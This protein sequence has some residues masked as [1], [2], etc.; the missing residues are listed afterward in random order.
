MTTALVQNKA[1]IMPQTTTLT[2]PQESEKVEIKNLNDFTEKIET[3]IPTCGTIE[4]TEEQ[5]KALYGPVNERDIE[6]RPDGLIYLPWIEYLSRLR[7]AFGMNWA[8]VP[9]CMPKLIDDYILWG[10]YLVIQGK[11]AGYAI[12]E[13]EYHLINKKMSWGD[14]CEGAKSNALMRLCKGLGISLELWRP[15]F[16]RR[17]KEKYAETYWDTDRNGNRKQCWRK[18]GCE[19]HQQKQKSMRGKHESKAKK[20]LEELGKFIDDAMSGAKQ[21]RDGSLPRANKEE[22]A[23]IPKKAKKTTSFL[24]SIDQLKAKIDPDTFNQICKPYEPLDKLFDRAKQV[25]LYNKLKEVL[26]FAVS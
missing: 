11:L 21:G 5:K 15:S 19:G 16:V 26:V 4:L 23:A 17:W 24:E 14:A 9:Q 6:I 12:G 10:F 20:D 25:E 22:K 2:A 8:I 13:Q 1:E 7:D 18:K 3:L